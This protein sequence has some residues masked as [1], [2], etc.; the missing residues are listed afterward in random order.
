MGFVDK[1][2]T[3]VS[4]VMKTQEYYLAPLD[5][6][7]NSSTEKPPLE[8]EHDEQG[9]FYDGLFGTK[10]IASQ[11]ALVDA[12][13]IF[14]KDAEGV[15]IP[16]LTQG[17][18]TIL[19]MVAINAAQRKRGEPLASTLEVGNLIDQLGENR[20]QRI[21]DARREPDNNEILKR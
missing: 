10:L 6:H 9:W 17:V 1:L 19:A 11:G 14:A 8:I 5:E 20:W 3:A 12:G 16:I 7:K 2:K 21:E 15:E 4:I 13:K 18:F